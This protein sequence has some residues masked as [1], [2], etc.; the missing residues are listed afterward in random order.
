MKAL[1]RVLDDGRDPYRVSSQ[2][3]D[4]VEVLFYSFEREEH[5]LRWLG[6]AISGRVNCL[7]LFEFYTTYFKECTRKNVNELMSITWNSHRNS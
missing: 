2:L 7:I 6:T 3:C 4:I 5:L 1:L